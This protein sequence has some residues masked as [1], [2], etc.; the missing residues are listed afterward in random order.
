MSSLPLKQVSE[1]CAKR[2]KHIRSRSRSR[3]NLERTNGK[4]W[5][6][7]HSTYGEKAA[8]FKAPCKYQVNSN[9]SQ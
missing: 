3:S 5:C 7:Y 1:L 6:W 9:D 4:G 2:P 8:K